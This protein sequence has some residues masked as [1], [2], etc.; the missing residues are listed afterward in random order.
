MYKIKKYLLYGTNEHL[1]ELVTV[2]QKD[3]NGVTA[4]HPT[5]S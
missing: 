4:T 2:W 1:V 3:L 5:T